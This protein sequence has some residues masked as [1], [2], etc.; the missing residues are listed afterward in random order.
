M[1]PETR[2]DLR[3]VGIGV[4]LVIV[5]IFANNWNSVSNRESKQLG[6]LPPADQIATKSYVDDKS[7]L[8]MYRLEQV[9]SKAE[10]ND[11]R[12]R[13]AIK[14]INRICQHIG[15]TC[16]TQNAIYRGPYPVPMPQPELAWFPLIHDKRRPG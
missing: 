9:E 8:P 7:S 11:K 4:A 15:M 1:S 2:A 5:T 10:S 12:S 3:S 13:T 16:A 14:Q 6:N